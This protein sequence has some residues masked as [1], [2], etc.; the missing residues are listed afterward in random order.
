MMAVVADLQ[1][2][3]ALFLKVGRF[4]ESDRQGDLRF[5]SSGSIPH[6]VA[7]T[8]G[9]SRE[10]AERSVGAI[11][12]RFNPDVI[13]SAGL[14]SSA[15]PD[16]S[17]G[18][19]V[20]CNRIMAVEGPAYSWR[21]SDALEIESDPSIMERV[22]RQMTVSDLRFEVGACVTLPQ[23]VVN[24][25][26][27][28]WL[29]R[30]FDVAA[31]DLEGYWTASVVQEFRLPCVPV[32]AIVDTMEQDVSLR[33]V[34]VLR[35]PPARRALHSFGY[36]AGNPARLIELARLSSQA[37]KARKSLAQFLYRLSGT[38]IAMGEN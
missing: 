22:R 30:T 26:M 10:E 28:E 32:R 24:S 14:A 15:D 21:M 11:V 1:R 6:V 31:A 9:F 35:Q 18:E 12:S 7:A 37:G 5:F 33:A 19:I 3:I 20:I 38:R 36:T 13:V 29:G 23:P 16:L 25:P 4:S 17:A 2:D 8:G 34:E 27:K